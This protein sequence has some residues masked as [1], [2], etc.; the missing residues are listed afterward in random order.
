MNM[1]IQNGWIICFIASYII[2]IINSISRDNI[3][4]ISRFRLKIFLQFIAWIVNILGFVLFIFWLTKFNN[5][6]M[7]RNLWIIALVTIIICFGALIFLIGNI[8]D[9]V[10]N[11]PFFLLGYTFTIF[12]GTLISF[13]VRNKK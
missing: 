1:L 2:H 4:D 9:K 10:L 3:N 13:L 8:D 12:L 5:V 7:L 11:I 6:K